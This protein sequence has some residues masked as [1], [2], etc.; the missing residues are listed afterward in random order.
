MQLFWQTA[1]LISENMNETEMTQRAIGGDVN[2]FESLLRSYESQAYNVALRL[3][4]NRQ[5]AEDATQEGFFRAY[6]SMHTFDADRPFAPWLKKII[7]NVCL[8]RIE[9]HEPLPLE[10]DSTVVARDL[11]P[12]AESLSHERSRQIRAALADLPPH[13][14]AVIE[15]RHF[16][17]LSYAEIAE[18]LDRSLGDV[19]SDLFRARKL[20]ADKLRETV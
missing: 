10:D 12:E 1:V 5:D 15:L 4:G 18:A 7:V 14:R 16:N 8:N 17:D 2:A 13:Y 11:G 20:L 6:R 3:L 9:K 19:K